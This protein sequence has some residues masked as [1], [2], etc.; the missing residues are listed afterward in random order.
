MIFPAQSR[1]DLHCLTSYLWRAH[2]MRGLSRY[3][4]RCSREHDAENDKNPRAFCSVTSGSRFISGAMA[5]EMLPR[6][7]RVGVL[8]HEI[9]HLYLPA[10]ETP[11]PE[12]DVD[13]WIS[14]ELAESGYHYADCD[15][16]KPWLDRKNN[17]V[18]AKAL[19]CVDKSF[20]KKIGA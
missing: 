17:V 13:T 3:R 15:Y 11:D 7:W 19:E 14:S 8:L 4:L 5:L 20:L 1:R 2:R 10:I 9:V 16:V 12:I 18:R 6:Q